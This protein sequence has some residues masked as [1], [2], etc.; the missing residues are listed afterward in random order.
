MNITIGIDPGTTKSAWVVYD[1]ESKKILSKRID[2]NTDLLAQLYNIETDRRVFVF[3][4][5]E[6]FGMP[7]GKEVFETVWWI[8]RFWEALGDVQRERIYRSDIK[9][10][11]CGSRRAKD[12]NIRQALLDKFESSGGGKCPQVGTK[13][14]PGP[15]YGI[16]KD[17]WSAVAI[18]VTYWEKRKYEIC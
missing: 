9:M 13:K 3:E 15:L 6:S 8:G 14:K 2:C 7:V 16:S 17:L 12:S 5:I 4:W 18:A 11:L 10:H 1:G